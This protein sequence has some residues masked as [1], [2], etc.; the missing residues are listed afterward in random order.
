MY[1]IKLC[2]D[3]PNN[4]DHRCKCQKFFV[5][6]YTHVSRYKDSDNTVLDSIKAEV[7]TVIGAARTLY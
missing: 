5:L 7:L 6:I 3:M 4:G 1:G 2:F